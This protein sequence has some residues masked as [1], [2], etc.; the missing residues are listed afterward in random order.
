MSHT[1]EHTAKI[2]FFPDQS[3]P[4]VFGS[5]KW[6]FML[7]HPETLAHHLNEDVEDLPSESRSQE[8]FGD[9][10]LFW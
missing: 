10:E 9:D 5:S 7:D 1:S 3:P 8:R 6:E 4:E 2:R